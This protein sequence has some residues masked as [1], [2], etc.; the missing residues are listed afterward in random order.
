MSTNNPIPTPYNVLPTGSVAAA[1][2]RAKGQ[3]TTTARWFPWTK[4][5]FN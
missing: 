2:P 3:S 5:K 4:M 1:V